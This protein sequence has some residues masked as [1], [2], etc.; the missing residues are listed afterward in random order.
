MK[1]GQRRGVSQSCYSFTKIGHEMKE[2]EVRL[3]GGGR[4]AGVRLISVF[5]YQDEG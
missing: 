4:G 3:E 5:V 1:S 2:R